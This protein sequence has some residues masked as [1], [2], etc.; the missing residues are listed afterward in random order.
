MADEDKAVPD[1]KAA[2]E[3]Q[4]GTYHQ[5]FFLVLAEK[6]QGRIEQMAA[7]QQ[8]RACNFRGRRLARKDRIDFSGFEFGHHANFSKCKWRGAEWREHEDNRETFTF[9]RACFTSATFGH[10]ARF[11][12]SAF[13]NGAD[14][15]GV[16]F[17]HG[18]SFPKAVFGHGAFFKDAA[19][20]ER[21]SFHSAAFGNGANFNGAAFGDEAGFNGATFGNWAT[22]AK[23]KFDSWYFSARKR[24][25]AKRRSIGGSTGIRGTCSPSPYSSGPTSPARPLATGPASRARTS[26]V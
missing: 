6:R 26:I 15:S 16:K 23:I 13:G 4:S 8:R 5:A 22:F 3:A 24:F 18:A 14:F 17:E 21:A 2:A 11:Y 1:D 9:G 20:G 7:R 25:S 19:F 10:R 12:S